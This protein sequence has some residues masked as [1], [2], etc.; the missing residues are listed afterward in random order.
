MLIKC[1]SLQP[2]LFKRKILLLKYYLTIFKKA[3]YCPSFN[4]VC[5]WKQ[6]YLISLSR[7][8]LVFF[9]KFHA[10][11]GSGG[12]HVLCCVL[13]FGLFLRQDQ[14][15]QAF[16]RVLFLM[17]AEMTVVALS[18]SQKS[19]VSKALANAFL[20]GVSGSARAVEAPLSSWDVY[21]SNTALKTHW[22]H[23]C[24]CCI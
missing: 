19:R 24:P 5:Y 2:G 7:S 21:W 4:A 20:V 22:K 13:G 23:F 9:T 3:K 18:I 6:S 10:F 14:A 11:K 15:A 12:P 17:R 16:C 1:V 8:V